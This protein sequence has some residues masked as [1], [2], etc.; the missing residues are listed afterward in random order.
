M[1]KVVGISDG[2]TI[3]V[4]HEDKAVQVRSYGMAALLWQRR[5]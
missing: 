3:S 2:D 1:G 5:R 4:L